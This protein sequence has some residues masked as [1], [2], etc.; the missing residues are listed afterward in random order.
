MSYILIFVFSAFP[1]PLRSISPYRTDFDRLLEVLPDR[2]P[3][4]GRVADVSGFTVVVFLRVHLVER[5][6][7]PAATSSEDNMIMML[8]DDIG[9]EMPENAPSHLISTAGSQ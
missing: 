1:P 7:T 8:G 9:E 6:P 4:I 5:S 3:N 2:R